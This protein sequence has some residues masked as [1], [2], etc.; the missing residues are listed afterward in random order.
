MLIKLII[1]YKDLLI[2]LTNYLNN[3]DMTSEEMFINFNLFK[4]FNIIEFLSFYF[5]AL[6][7]CLIIRKFIRIIFIKFF[8]LI[9]CTIISCWIIFLL[10]RWL[11]NSLAL[12]SSS[13]IIAI[14]GLKEIIFSI[15]AILIRNSNSS[16]NY[17]WLFWDW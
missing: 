10:I 7:N 5:I 6:I 11:L 17:Q 16:Y 15:V 2:I 9:S 8:L 4:F 13:V 3:I 14:S 1:K 12:T